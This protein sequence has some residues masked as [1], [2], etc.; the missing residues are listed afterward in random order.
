LEEEMKK[1]LFVLALISLAL[2][3]CIVDPGRGYGDRG[4]DNHGWANNGHAEVH[5]D[6]EQQ[7]NWNR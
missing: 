7:D 1:T 6:H 4:Y 2:T 5:A 3:G